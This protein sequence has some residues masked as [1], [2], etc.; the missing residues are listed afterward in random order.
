MTRWREAIWPAVGLGAVAF[1]GYL[2]IKELRG[3]SLATIAD[4][5]EAIPPWRWALA[6]LSTVVA[7]FAL[8]WYDQ[9]ALLHLRR[10]LGWRFVG[11]VSFVAYALG[12]NIGASVVS[13]GFVRYRAYSQEGL[14]TAE[15]G[16]IVAF[17]SL[18]FTLGALLTG[19][20]TLLIEPE[21]VNRWLPAGAWGRR[22][23]VVAL[24][25]GP[26]L[27]TLGSLLNFRPV[28]IA[29]FR[30]TY[31]RPWIA[32][33]QLIVGP[34][35]LIGAAG[36]IYFALPAATNPGFLTVLAVFLASFSA[37][38]VSHA[39]GGLG[40]LE[41]AFLKAMP[42]TPKAEVLAALLAFRLLYLIIPL[43]VSLAIV[44][45]HENRRLFAARQR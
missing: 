29:G 2:L 3:Q 31:P 5:F 30:L 45:V 27:Y 35:E 33:R 43:V 23:I 39:P 42:E 12:H 34:I 7:Y 17:T 25:F 1:A 37:A 9:I 40:V 21:L 41:L 11:V 4:A 26:W 32:A 18:T 24:L 28:R 13:G 44:A 16:V 6:A 20:V 22:A 10:R 15:I 38:L 14:S 19:G 8:A 36:I